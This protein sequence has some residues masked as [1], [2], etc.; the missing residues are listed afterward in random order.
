MAELTKAEWEDIKLEYITT[1]ISLR[2]LAQKHGVSFT[3]CRTKCTRDGWV[4]ARKDYYSSITQ[5]SLQRLAKAES[6]NIADMITLATG[7][8]MEKVKQATAE[9]DVFVVETQAERKEYGYDED[10]RR[11][12]EDRRLKKSVETCKRGVIDRQGLKALTSALKD[13]KEIAM[14]QT[15]L[16]EQEQ[17]ARIEKLRKEAQQGEQGDKEDL[18]GIVLMPDIMPVPEDNGDGQ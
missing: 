15:A 2:D 7:E 9:L 13:L 18:Y 6:K 8:L 3:A 4:Q 1:E 17:Q 12:S 11:I 10:G 16:Q 14:I 5:K